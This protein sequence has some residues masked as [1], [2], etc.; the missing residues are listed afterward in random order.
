MADGA[1]NGNGSKNRPADEAALSARLRSLGERL[2]R[3]PASPR[4]EDR[5]P[6]SGDTKT[7][8]RGIRLSAELVAGILVG[9]AIGWFLDKWLGISP[10][11]FIVFFLLGF[12]AGI[13]N[14]IRSAG[15]DG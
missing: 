1:R 12:V 9:A 8:A 3:Q 14:V 15:R 5:P 6:S 11:G 4:V 13:F 7:I 10:W 2:G